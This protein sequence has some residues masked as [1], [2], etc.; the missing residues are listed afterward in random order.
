MSAKQQ[1]L[2]GS[3][4]DE[5]E[6]SPE[7]VNAGDVSTYYNILVDLRYHQQA[8][9][10]FQARELDDYLSDAMHRLSD[11]DLICCEGIVK[12]PAGSNSA[13]P[14][15]EYRLNPNAIDELDAIDIATFPC[16]HRGFRNYGTHGYGCQFEHCDARYS[17]ETA[18]EVL[19]E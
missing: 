4:R 11:R 7:P 19:G 9:G 8:N 3:S 18:S 10:A 14:I 15:K 13:E 5:P 6:K 17:E 2:D 12:P 1:T 16:G